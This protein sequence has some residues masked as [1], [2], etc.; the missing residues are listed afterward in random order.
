M[1]VRGGS[2]GEPRPLVLQC[3]TVLCKALL[4][5]SAVVE[6]TVHTTVGDGFCR[7]FLQEWRSGVRN[8]EGFVV[9]RKQGEGFMVLRGASVQQF[10][11]IGGLGSMHAHPDF[12]GPPFEALG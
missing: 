12:H 10:I 5:Y 7:A 1:L 8:D 4:L 11:L 9:I 3:R 6:I 2:G